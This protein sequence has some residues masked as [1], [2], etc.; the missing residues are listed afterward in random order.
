MLQQK[1]LMKESVTKILKESFHQKKQRKDFQDLNIIQ[2][3]LENYY[4][5]KFDKQ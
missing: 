1:D 3:H 5:N 4:S 2:N